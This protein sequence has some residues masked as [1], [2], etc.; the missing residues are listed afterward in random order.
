MT[1]DWR[2]C[3]KSMIQHIFSSTAMF[4]RK[5]RSAAFDSFKMLFLPVIYDTQSPD[6]KGCCACLDRG[7]SFSISCLCEKQTAVSHFSAEP[8]IFLDV[9]L[10]SEGLRTLKL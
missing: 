7:H 9:G 10:C 3:S 6:K 5:L 2:D 8:D 4:E 1:N